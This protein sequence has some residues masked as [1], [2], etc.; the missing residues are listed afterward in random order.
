MCP[1]QGRALVPYQDAPVLAI[2]ST[3]ARLG[4]EHDAAAR[5]LSA[6]VSLDDKPITFERGPGRRA[7]AVVQVV[8]K[9]P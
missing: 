6:L 7:L 5:A 2:A 8:G 9:W 3:L 1:S 4:Q